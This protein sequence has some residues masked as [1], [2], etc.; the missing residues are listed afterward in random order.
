VSRI[1][2]IAGALALAIAGAA[3][4]ARAGDDATG[5]L[6]RARHAIDQVDY[7]GARKLADQAL[8][9]GGLAAAD[10]ARAHRLAGEIAA[11]LGDDAGARDHFVRWILL[12]PDAALPAGASPKLTGPFAAA[13]AEA[14]RLGAMRLDLTATR[15]GNQVTIALGGDD[16]LH[17]AGRLRVDAGGGPPA[18]GPPPEVEVDAGPGAFTATVEVLDDRGDVLARRTVSAV[19][20]VTPAG[21]A[22]HRVPAAVR[23]PTWTAIAAASLGT[24]AYFAWRVGKDKQDLDALNAASPMHSFDEARAI[25]DRGRRDA[26][27]TNIALGVAAVAAVGAVVTFVVDRRT[28]EVEPLAAPG[29]AGASASVHF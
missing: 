13:R 3:P 17:L 15:A 9:Q 18:E 12:A 28:V 23:W 1:A 20:A 2:A 7:E 19:A 6:D 26:L 4:A 16:P 8:D 14:G 27:I 21:A 25:D 5:L 29:A 24:G 10:L 11:A 22:H